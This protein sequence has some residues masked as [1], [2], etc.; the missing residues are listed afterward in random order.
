ML[1]SDVDFQGKTVLIREKKRSRKQR[2]TRRVPLTPLLADVLRVW[3]ENHPGGR[4]LFCHR[5]DVFRSKKRSK[6]TGHQDE[7][8]R[9]SSLKGRMA[10]VKKR[11]LSA[12]GT[13]TRDETHD[14]F[15]RTV[16]GSKWE[17]LSGYHL[18]RHSFIS[19]LRQPGRGPAID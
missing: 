19:I 1:I 2:T 10:T 15:K 7:K 9:P 4:Y 3:L 16:A 5:A 13:L 8:V 17:V 14:H 6:T 11:E 12:L 18:L